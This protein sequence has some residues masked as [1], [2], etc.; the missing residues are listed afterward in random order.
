MR[1]YVRN[2]KIQ[3]SLRTNIVTMRTLLKLKAIYGG[4]AFAEAAL[5]GLTGAICRHRL[6]ACCGSLSGTLTRRFSQ[7]SMRV[8]WRRDSIIRSA[9][10]RIPACAKP[11]CFAFLRSDRASFQ[12][13]APSAANSWR[14]HLG[15]P[16]CHLGS[17]GELRSP[18]PAESR[19]R[20]ELPAPQERGI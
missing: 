19:L 9:D 7:R 17:A 10:C 1:E 11:L 3:P 16:R 8:G 15:L 18:K 4:Y 20:A 6:N 12:S 14:R 13:D 2:C 5:H